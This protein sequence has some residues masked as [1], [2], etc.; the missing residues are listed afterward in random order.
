[1]K[2]SISSG[3]LSKRYLLLLAVAA[4]IV[5]RFCHLGTH[6]LWFDEMGQVIAAT[7]NWPELFKA[8]ASHL[9]PPLDYV[10]LKPITYLGTSDWMVRF[11][12]FLYGSA[13]LI[14]MYLFTRRIA[15]EPTAV[16]A[17]LLL[18]FSPMAIAYSQEARMY[19]LYLLLSLLSYVLAY[20]YYQ[21]PNWKRA[22]YLGLV[23]GLLLLTHYFGFVVVGLEMTLLMIAHGLRGA[24]AKDWFWLGISLGASVLIFLPWL[25]SFLGQ[26]EHSGGQIAYALQPDKLFYKFILNAFS[27]FTGAEEGP[28]YYLYLLLFLA[29]VITAIIKRQYV[30]A[31]LAMAVAAV[32]AGFYGL[33]FI[34]K[35]ATTRNLIFLLPVYLAVCAYA[36]T[37]LA[38]RWKYGLTVV[39]LAL[40]LLLLPP[41]YHYHTA[42][43][44][45]FKPDWKGVA[46][47]L[48]QH[49]GGA[50]KIIVTDKISRGC[51][52]YY[53]EPEAEYVVFREGCNHPENKDENAV[54]IWDQAVREK[55]AKREMKGWIIITPQTFEPIDRAGIDEQI[56]TVASALTREFRCQGKK[57]SVKIYRF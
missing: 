9:S 26:I 56:N 45:D 44:P 2:I 22:V 55:I 31:V 51:L 1:M 34:K 27:I 50:D 32:L 41:V 43:R 3:D 57:N 15:N 39:W 30:L 13:T 25:P 12:A 42:P 38:G 18:A 10:L 28:W 17:T 54:W 16:L 21:A 40:F 5:A 49:R 14:I 53:L 46:S 4:G 29:G 48:H 6:S 11:P 8:V 47:Y 24:K 23:N 52:A 33:S 36:I 19:S 20:D 37:A 7:S 35:I